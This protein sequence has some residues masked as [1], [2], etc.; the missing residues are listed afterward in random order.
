MTRRIAIARDGVVRLRGKATRWSVERGHM[1]W[2]YVVAPTG[3][4][5]PFRKHAARTYL[6]SLTDEELLGAPQPT[7]RVLR[8]WSVDE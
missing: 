1:A 5:R 8:D 2:W 7:E 3:E 4:R 6:E